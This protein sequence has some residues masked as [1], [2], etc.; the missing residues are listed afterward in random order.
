VNGAVGLVVSRAGRVFSVLGFTVRDGQ[1]A[2][3]DILADAGR[4]RGLAFGGLGG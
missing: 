2:A 4:L 1:I 3:I